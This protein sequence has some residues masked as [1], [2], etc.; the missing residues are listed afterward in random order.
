MDFSH[1]H[2]LLNHFPIIGA[3]VGVGL[4]LL[5][6]CVH[7]QDLRRSSLVVFVVTAL[8]T[9]PAFISGFGAQV[10]LLEN[11]D[12]SN[13]LIQRHLGSAELV[14]WFMGL[15]G[16][17]AAMALWQ[18]DRQMRPARWQTWGVLV[19]SLV[20]VVLLARTGNT[21]GQILH[22]E[23]QFG[24]QETGI[25]AFL[26]SFEPSPP[27]FTR[28][29]IASQW[30]WVFM[31]TMHFVGLVLVVGTIGLLNLRVLGFA[32]QLPIA[33]LN[34]LVPWGLA[35]FGINVV[36]GLLA[37]IG[38]SAYY[39]YNIAFMLKIVFVLLALAS[40]AL[41]YLTG[42]FRDCEDVGPG[43]DAPLRAKFSAGASLVLWFAVI[44]LGR[45]IQ[46]L[47][48]SIPR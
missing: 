5:S 34:K 45:Y 24:P 25:A 7:G 13:D 1:F 23:V 39:T 44:V 37:F 35:G 6:F 18:S 29:M 15:V 26:A 27:A 17:L 22:S 32:K 9:I 46:P 4:L 11:A 30:W 33:P 21:G 10:E 16:A 19:V 20:T 48:N 36:T 40:L 41:F 14:V 3:I 31:M 12:V 38:M 28:L 42:A 8:L 2:L 47:E 43:G